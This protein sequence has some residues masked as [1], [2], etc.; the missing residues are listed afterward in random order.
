LQASEENLLSGGAC[1]CAHPATPSLYQ[2]LKMQMGSLFA[3]HLQSVQ[4]RYIATV[5]DTLVLNEDSV[6]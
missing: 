3:F 4:R 1:C 6:P 2:F 5:S